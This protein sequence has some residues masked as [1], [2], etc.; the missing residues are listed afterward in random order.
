MGQWLSEL[1]L[2]K[3]L[4][5]KSKVNAV[6]KVLTILEDDYSSYNEVHEVFEASARLGNFLTSVN[7]EIGENI[8]VSDL[9]ILEEEQ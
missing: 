5:I 9:K 3:L 6:L 8:G 2:N 1:P 7:E 4:V